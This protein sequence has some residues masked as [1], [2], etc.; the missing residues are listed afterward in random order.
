MRP[1]WVIFYLPGCSWLGM[2]V[3]Y[4]NQL[5]DLKLVRDRNIHQFSLSLLIQGRFT[6]HESAHQH[7][8]PNSHLE[9][10][11]YDHSFI[12]W[13]PSSSLEQIWG[14]IAQGYVSQ[15]KDKISVDMVCGI[16]IKSQV[17]SKILSLLL[18]SNT[19]YY[20]L[21]SWLKVAF[22]KWQTAPF[23]QSSSA[24]FIS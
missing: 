9:V 15:S 13:P 8:P 1:F 21:K 20:W 12:C 10:T 2:S 4:K 6:E 18:C 19:G 3:W 16:I 22:I 5:W 14:L 11:L 24:V 23:A 17:A 7:P